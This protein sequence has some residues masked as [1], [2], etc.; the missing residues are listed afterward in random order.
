ME[1]IHDLLKCN[2]NLLFPSLDF[3]STMCKTFTQTL[4]Q[5]YNRELFT[6][7]ILKAKTFYLQLAR[8]F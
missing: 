7:S 1:T 8:N 4:C 6:T 3:D 5:N 2:K